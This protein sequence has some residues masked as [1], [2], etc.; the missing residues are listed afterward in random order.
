MEIEVGN[1]SNNPAGIRKGIREKVINT[2]G[3][4]I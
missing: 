3:A 1:P 2:R 4:R